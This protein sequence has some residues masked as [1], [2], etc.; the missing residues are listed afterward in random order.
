MIRML[1]APTGKQ[2][3]FGPLIALLLV[4]L[5]GGW[6]LTYWHTHPDPLGPAIIYT[7]GTTP[8]GLTF[9]YDITDTDLFVEWDHATGGDFDPRNKCPRDF[10]RAGF[11]LLCRKTVNGKFAKFL[12]HRNK[13]LLYRIDRD[14]VGGKVQAGLHWVTD[15]RFQAPYRIADPAFRGG[16]RVDVPDGRGGATI[17]RYDYGQAVAKRQTRWQRELFHPTHIHT[18]QCPDW[19]DLYQF[20]P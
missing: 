20:T 9:D 15:T 3:L 17:Q 7:Q 2:S 1:P 19:M 18:D 5:L 16:R 10:F 12:Y 13:K 11:V 4:L 14:E 8:S 6:L